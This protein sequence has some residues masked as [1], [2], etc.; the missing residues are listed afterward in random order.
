MLRRT[1]PSVALIAVLG[2]AAAARAFGPFDDAR[3][4]L[5]AGNVGTAML[6]VDTG[7]IAANTPDENGYTLLHYAAKIG[8]AEG[9]KALLDRGA[10]PTIRARD[11]K[12]PADLAT[13]D[14][15]RALLTA[16]RR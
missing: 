10:D 13:N 5:L 6:A 3:D 8:S 9:V 1:L 12:T 14:Q 15:V 16:P 4:N 2:W 11:G 7:A